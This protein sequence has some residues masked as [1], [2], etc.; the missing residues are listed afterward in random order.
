MGDRNQYLFVM[1]RIEA[2]SGPFLEVGSRDYGSTQDLRSL[3]PGQ[4]YV[5]V[6]MSEGPG[7][8]HMLNLTS[9]WDIIDETLGGERFGAIFCFSVLEH[10][11]NPFLMAEN[12]SRLLRPDGKVCLS[13]PFAWKF[14]GYPS[15]YW[16]F[17]H[18]GVRKLFPRL[19]WRI[20]DGCL[21]T[22]RTGDFHPLDHEIGK[23]HLSGK[24]HRRR[25]RWLRGMV[26]D[27]LSLLPRLGLLRWLLG[28]R[29]ILTPSMINMVGVLPLKSENMSSCIDGHRQNLAD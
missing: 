8:D 7:V 5:G 24:W 20:N 12:M 11:E 28:Y 25:S 17:T 13:V 15:D 1:N 6:D 14:H 9:E 29:Y 26:L 21:S 23:I 4:K 10:C 18:E 19:Q 3:Y 27:M 22:H 16:R 2:F